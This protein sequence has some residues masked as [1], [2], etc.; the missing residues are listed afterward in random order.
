L[1][2]RPGITDWASIKYKDENTILEKS[3]DPETDYI[4]IIL[5]DKIKYNLIFIEKNNVIEYLKIIFATIWKII[6]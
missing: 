5:P 3:L 4:N 6:F 1:K 2:I